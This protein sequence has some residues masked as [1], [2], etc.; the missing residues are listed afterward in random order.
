MNNYKITD[1]EL[2]NHTNLKAQG[3]AEAM[4]DYLPW[5]VLNVNIEFNSSQGWRVIDNKT[6]FIYEVKAITEDNKEAE[7]INES[8][9]RRI[10]E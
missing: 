10:N 5:P 7:L 2:C 1:F 6:G 8:E 9:T 3:V 4:F